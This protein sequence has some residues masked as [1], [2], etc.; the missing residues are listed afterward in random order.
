MSWMAENGGYMEYLHHGSES[1]LSGASGKRNRRALALFATLMLFGGIAIFAYFATGR[2]W[3]IAATMVDDRVGNMKSYTA[4]VFN[5]IGD[6]DVDDMEETALLVHQSP[7]ESPSDDETKESDGYTEADDIAILNASES[8]AGDSDSSEE[9]SNLSHGLLPV[10]ENGDISYNNLSDRIM[11]IFYRAMAKIQTDGQDR[12]YAADVRDLYET[13]GAEACTLNISD[14]HYYEEPIVYDLGRKR[15]G[16]FSISSYTSRSRLSSVSSSLRADG[17][18]VV[19]CVSPRASMVASF[20]GIDIVVTTLQGDWP[21]DGE[22]GDA[23]EVQAPFEGEVGIILISE[24]N[25]PI[26]K[27]ITE[28]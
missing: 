24:S 19:V 25:V 5:G 28:I 15:I 27:S 16:I 9:P 21:D 4:I 12:V 22:K 2:G 11:S 10:D 18:D 6:R 8:F 14:L 13:A 3:S 26:Y 7:N 23:L 1:A 17:A 20:D